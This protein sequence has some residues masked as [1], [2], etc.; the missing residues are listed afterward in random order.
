MGLCPKV[1]YEILLDRPKASNFLI[2]YN[3]HRLSTI[4][5]PKAVP[6][7]IVCGPSENRRNDSKM[8][9]AGCSGSYW[10]R[11]HLLL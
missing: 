9:A 3:H 6:R 1:T 11:I 10:Y 5:I 8:A 2:F 4:S 7:R